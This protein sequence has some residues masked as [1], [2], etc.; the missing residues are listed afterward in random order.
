MLEREI[1]AVVCKYAKS[2]GFF[3][4]KFSSP[5]HA[6]VPDR[7]FVAPHQRAFWIEFKRDGGK[8][9]PLQERECDKLV[10]CG[11]EVYV[12]D[13]VEKGKSVIDEQFRIAAMVCAAFLQFKAMRRNDD[14][15]SVH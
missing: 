11:F 9:T 6:G 2:K 1:E 14:N 13:S 4:Y 5:S 3:V 12:V 15:E 10:D 7:M 8:L